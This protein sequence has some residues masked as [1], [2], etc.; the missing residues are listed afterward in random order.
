MTCGDVQGLCPPKCSA[1]MS[2]CRTSEARSRA[3]RL[4]GQIR[5]VVQST[6]Q[7]GTNG[8]TYRLPRPPRPPSHISKLVLSTVHF[9][10]PT[11]TRTDHLR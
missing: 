4:T 6:V 5:K 9:G 10:P 7:G 8:T 2:A 1:K 3:L 11:W